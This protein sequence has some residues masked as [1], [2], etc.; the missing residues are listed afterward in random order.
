MSDA[1]SRG[2]LQDMDVLERLYAQRYSCRAYLDRPV[3]RPVI[4][5]ILSVA[6]RTASWCNAQPW[7][8]WITSGEETGRLRGA[9]LEGLDSQAVNPDFE[10]PREYQGVH[11]A[12]RR[13]CGLALYE[14][15]GVERGDKA[16]AER[17]ARE[18][19]RFFGAPHA[20]IVTCEESLG[21]Y[22]AIDCGA[23]VASFMLAARSMGVASI[24]QASLAARPDLL[25]RHFG[26]PDRE[27]V[28]CGVSFGYADERHPINGFR[29]TRAD[30]ADAVVWLGHP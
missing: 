5:R 25:R 2:N 13:E 10:W 17:Q 14:S 20:M 24:A 29:T 18:N 15:V 4:E 26:M 27:R 22:A 30:L 6:Q 12:R 9:L 28:V 3:P 16:A 8:L 7:K 1:T 23:Y 21:D 19:F 11:L